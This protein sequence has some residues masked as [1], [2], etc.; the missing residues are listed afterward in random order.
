M[1]RLLAFLLALSVAGILFPDAKC[2]AACA[3]C[4]PPAAS[5]RCHHSSQPAPRPDCG[6]GHALTDGW[7]QPT[8][9]IFSP[10]QSHSTVLTLES[11]PVWEPV[12]ETL[13]TAVAVHPPPLIARFITLRV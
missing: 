7:L 2:A 5:S 12:K 6:F 11:L 13:V 9:K 4:P 10:T 1:A 8:A 3:H